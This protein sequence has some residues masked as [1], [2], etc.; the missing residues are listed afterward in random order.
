[1]SKTGT[2]VMRFI[3]DLEFWVEDAEM[4]K[5]DTALPLV[6]FKKRA[7]AFLVDFFLM[8]AVIVISTFHFDLSSEI[9]ITL[10]F[11]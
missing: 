7:S 5:K 10:V 11:L 2:I 1:M 9:L 3:K 4:A 6:S 8:L